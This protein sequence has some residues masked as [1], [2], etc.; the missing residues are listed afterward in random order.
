MGN[1]TLTRL[2]LSSMLIATLLAVFM[3]SYLVEKTLLEYME[4]SAA[5]VTKV[6]H[7]SRNLYSDEAVNRVKMLPEVDASNRYLD[8]P[9]GIPNPATFTI[10]LGERLSA[11]HHQD[12]LQVKMYSDL[13][14]RGRQRNPLDNFEKDAIKQARL[15]P[16]RPFKRVETVDGVQVLRYAN[17]MIMHKGCV[18][19]HFAH[20]D[21]PKRDW[22]IGDV[23]GVLEV[24]QPLNYGG[25]TYQTVYY[26]RVAS[27]AISIFCIAAIL[28]ML[29]RN[30]REAIIR[31]NELRQRTKSLEEQV[32]TDGLTNIPNRRRFDQALDDAWRVCLRHGDPL[33]I[34]MIDIDYFKQYNDTFGHLEGDQCLV[35]IANCIAQQ[36]NR[37]MDLVCRYGG[38]EFVVLLPAT[39]EKGAELVF[40][41]MQMAI[42]DL[43]MPHPGS[44]LLEYVT[45]SIGCATTV[46]SNNSDVAQLLLQTD[47]ALYESKASGRNCLTVIT[48]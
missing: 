26:I 27:A 39:D 2:I 9:H 35:K 45:V 48:I 10:L 30:R 15:T 40:S 8:T 23:R 18:D 20:P 38:E 22:Q 36:V 3:V 46:V 25:S 13:P 42:K 37:P 43:A 7:E 34:G 17:P 14:F 31:K 5:L 33:S 21:S 24:T 41:G 4:S 19:C 44:P 47:S 12:S 28:V 6:V 29:V 32:F 1:A 16:E 11:I